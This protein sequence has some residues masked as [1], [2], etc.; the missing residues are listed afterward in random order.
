VNPPNVSAPT[1]SGSSPS[2]GADHERAT[3][4]VSTSHVNCRV[5][6][7]E[8]S[9]GDPTCPHCGLSAPGRSI[10]SGAGFWIRAVARIIDD[11]ILG[12]GLGL[13]AGVLAAIVL[14]I[15]QLAEV[16]APGWETRVQGVSAAG[17]GLSLLGV[18]AYHCLCEGIH[19][20]T[21]GKLI[22]RVRVVTDVG[23]PCN[24]KGALIRSLAWYLDSLF[25]GLVAYHSMQRSPLNQRYGDVWGK[26]AVLKATDIPTDSRRSSLRFLLG[27]VLG[28]GCR[29]VLIALGFV[30]KGM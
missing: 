13:V 9:E 2:N 26:T 6:G 29:T 17:V 28:A 30:L 20:A 16:I 27:L 12:Y 1:Y 19:G 25:F 5:C 4:T 14:V 23:R 7:T 15:L 11:L 10:G 24:F 3:F 18:C 22:C 8:V 21:L